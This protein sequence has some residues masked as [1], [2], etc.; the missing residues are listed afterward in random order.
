MHD[1]TLVL[2]VH[3]HVSAPPA[4][5]NHLVSMLGSNTP[6]ASPIGK[7]AGP[8]GVPVE[9]FRAAAQR[10]VDYIDAR[11]IDV[12]VLGPRPYLHMGWM[13][14]HL[15]PA[16][17][18]YVNDMIH[19]Q[20]E[21][22]P[23]RFV[24]AAQLPV[25]TEAPDASGCVPEIERCVRE[26][27]FVAVY[28]P[29]DASG[30]RATPGLHE[31]YWYPVYAK[32][33]ELDVPVIVHGTNSLDPRFRV[34][35][36]NYQLGFLTEQYLAGQFLGHSDVFERFPELRVIICHCGGA[37]DRFIPTDD[38]LPQKDLSRNL[39]YDSCGYDLHFLEAAIKQRGV[40]RMC[41]GTEAPGSGGAVRPETGRTSDDLVPV[42]DAFPFLTAE[43]KRKI[44]HDNPLRVVPGIAKA[45]RYQAAFAD[46]AP[47]S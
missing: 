45:G 22:F 31:P 15:V 18:R 19:Q 40:D 41:F 9:D 47:A 23:D 25:V 32:C 5:Y 4:A 3:G 7:P 17:A 2:D 16:W 6:F 14:P 10:H 8:K 28:A 37:L 35:P 34:V 29:P 33:Q 11:N 13:E 38:H 46:A 42:I 39:F 43:D 27:G 36:K 24:G 20:V 30:R 26:L 1:G 44:F 12:Q 21:F